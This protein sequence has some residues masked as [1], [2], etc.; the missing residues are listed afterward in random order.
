MKGLI[1]KKRPLDDLEL[2]I[3][4]WSVDD[5]DLP[6]RIA[7]RSSRRILQYDLGQ[8]RLALGLTQT[9]VA[10]RMKTSQSS[11]ARIEAGEHDVRVDTLDRYARVLGCSV[12]LTLKIAS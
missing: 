4:E 11:I 9:E 6:A 3:A 5:P 1:V 12:E 2:L 10:K 8:R 7:A